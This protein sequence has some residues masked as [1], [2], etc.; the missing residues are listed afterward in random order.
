MLVAAVLL[1][2][3]GTVVGA[4]LGLR[5]WLLL[6]CSPV[7]TLGVTAAL[8]A[9]TS[10]LGIPWNPWMFTGLTLLLSVILA[11]VCWPWRRNPPDSADRW[12]L[13]HHLSVAGAVLVSGALGATAVFR[14]TLRL[15][16]VQQAWDT[17]FHAGAV[18]RIAELRDADSSVLASVGKPASTDFYY[19]DVYHALGALLYDLLPIS[20]VQVINAFSVVTPAL[21]CLS[22]APLL[23][24]LSPRPVFVVSGV[25]LASAVPYF[26]T[27]LI[28]YGPLLP[29]ALA[30]AAAPAVVALVDSL[31]NR[32]RRQL[33]LALGLA[34]TGLAATHPS[35]AVAIAIWCLAHVVLR[36]LVLRR[37]GAAGL[38]GLSA[39]AILT[40]LLLA[41]QFAALRAN[42][43]ASAGITKPPSESPGAAIGR[44]VV[45]NPNTAQPHWTLA[46]LLVVGVALA[47]RMRSMVSVLAAGV[48]FATLYVW[49]AAYNTRLT[50][51]VTALWWDN[52]ERLAA[53]FAVPAVVLAALGL[54]AAVDLLARAAPRLRPQWL[55][56]QAARLRAL[57]L[58]VT[59][60]LFWLATSFAYSGT[61]VHMI[62]VE[63]GDGP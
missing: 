58:A 49:S 57:A 8:T 62:R 29:F 23:R 36:V 22:M 43:A 6:G 35:V 50:H 1:T 24:A 41:P 54:T 39:A 63:Y 30:L 16:A 52:P 15:H 7:L 18:R 56:A 34:A 38:L 28:A 5:G 14:G 33:V 9:I 47:I 2:L 45:F 42:A 53:L 17:P 27:G 48:A 60:L 4:S 46:L 31:L 26:P 32:P 12:A 13:R 11:T 61:H 19:P 3:P 40:A 21:F 10:A 51:A 37:A 55:P 20:T 25:I 59:V 44:L